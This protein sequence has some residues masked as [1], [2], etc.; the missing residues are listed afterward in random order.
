[1]ADSSGHGGTGVYDTA[2]AA[3]AEPGPLA[4]DA[5]TAVADNGA[6]RAG[7]SAPSLPV[8]AQPRTLEG[9]VNTTTG[10]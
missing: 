8:G 3:L 6:G 9:W 7:S 5:G 4:N 10:G 1:M 2:D